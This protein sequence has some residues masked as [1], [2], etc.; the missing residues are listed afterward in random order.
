MWGTGEPG[1]WSEIDLLLLTA[2]QQYE[3]GICSGCGQPL[4]HT[5]ELAYTPDFEVAEICCS[6]CQVLEGR[7][8][9]HEP[10]N[11]VKRYVRNHM[12]DNWR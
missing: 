11:G 10:G 6:A 8:K 9:N 5:T 3:A 7:N 12:S 4:G 1:V 2:F